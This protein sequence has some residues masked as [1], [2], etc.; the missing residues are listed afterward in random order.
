LAK[1]H[2]A[3]CH[4]YPD[5]SLL[6]KA[7]WEKQILPRMANM[8]GFYNSPNQR[9]QLIDPNTPANLYPS[10]PLLEKTDWEAIKQFYLSQAPKEIIP[11]VPDI[12]IG[13]KGFKVIQP[14]FKIS[15]PST[16]L[17]KFMQD[18][19]IFVGDALSKKLVQFDKNLNLLKS[20]NILEGAVHLRES[21]DGYWILSMGSFSPTDQASG[22][23]LHLPKSEN[24]KARIIADQ[25]KRPVHAAYGDLDQDGRTDIV[26]CEFGKWAGQLNILYNKG[27]QEFVPRSLVQQTGASKTFLRDFNQDGRL[28]IMVLFA[29][30]QEGI[31]LFY[32]QGKGQFSREVL[33]SFSPSHGSTNM[34]LVDLENDGDWDIVYTAGD[35][36][37]FNPI[38]KPYHGVYV[39]EN[40]GTN[41]YTQK[42]FYPLHGANGVKIV[43]FDLDGDLDMA[44]ISFFPDFAKG[45]KESFVYLENQGDFS[46]VASTFENNSQGRW[47][48]LDANDKDGD[49]D[50]DLILGALTFEVIPDL[51]YTDRWIEKGLPFIVLENLVR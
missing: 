11:P 28:D 31:S 27:N 24:K 43:D 48:V 9:A 12:P 46:F 35:N 1:I 17:V 5:P 45:A 6:D 22:M 41:K 15:P 39:F 13:L 3:T 29:Q 40:N 7:S 30:G 4:Q 34:E 19:S 50:V 38:L 32:N 42:Y 44:A 36:A 23:L 16:T 2:C 47:I 25:L 33:L 21:E 10:E 20:G 37:D 26:L 14:A 18:Q 51:G 8:M 49:G